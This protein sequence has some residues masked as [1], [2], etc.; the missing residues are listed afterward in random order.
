MTIREKQIASLSVRP[1][2]PREGDIVGYSFHGDVVPNL[3][4]DAAVKII[5]SRENGIGNTGISF[6]SNKITQVR[7][8]KLSKICGRPAV[9]ICRTI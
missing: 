6:E 2:S 3:Y 7:V 1:N 4:N 5:I 8:V 9:Q